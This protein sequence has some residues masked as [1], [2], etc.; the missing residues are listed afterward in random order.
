[1][2]R[3]PALIA[4]VLAVGTGASSC[5]HD[6]ASSGA[7]T[8]DNGRRCSKT[9]AVS[10]RA[11]AID[12]SGNLE[13]VDLDAIEATVRRVTDQPLMSIFQGEDGVRVRTGCVYGHLDANGYSFLLRKVGGVWTILDRTEWVA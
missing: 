7:A 13:A 9:R 2:I 8:G 3:T 11:G 10:W 12:V 1:M 4:A 6:S 5:A